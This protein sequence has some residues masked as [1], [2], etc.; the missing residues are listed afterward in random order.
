MP[1]G[2]LSLAR[3]GSNLDDLLSWLADGLSRVIRG[4]L[5]VVG[6]HRDG[7]LDL[8]RLALLDNLGLASLEFGILANLYLKRGAL[9]PLHGLGGGVT[10]GSNL[11]DLL[12]RLSNALGFGRCTRDLRVL[13]GL[14]GGHLILARLALLDSLLSAGRQG[15]IELNLGLERNFDLGLSGVRALSLGTHTDDR[16]GRLLGALRGDGRVTRRLAVDDLLRRSHDLGAVLA[17]LVDDLLASLQRIIKDDFRLER[18]WLLSLGD[19][20][21]VLSLRAV[22]DDFLDRFLGGFALSKVGLITNRTEDGGEGLFAVLALLNN[23]GLT[24]SEVRVYA[25]RGAVGHRN[26]PLGLLSILSGLDANLDDLIDGLFGDLLLDRGF[27]IRLRVGDLLGHRDGLLARL[28]LGDGLRLARRHRRVKLDLHT[29]RHLSLNR[30]RGL[31]RCHCANSDDL[32]DRFFRA[33][34]RHFRVT[35]R[36]AVHDLL[37][38][39]HD[40][41][42]GLTLLVDLLFTLLE[43]V[44]EDDLGLERH[45]LLR[46]G[47]HGGVLSSRAVFDDLVDRVLGLLLFR[48]HRCLVAR[49]REIS[50]VGLLA[51]DA[52]LDDLDLTRLQIRVRA[53]LNLERNLGSPGDLLGCRRRLGAD[54]DD[55]IDGLLGDLLLHGGFAIGLRVGDLLRHGDGLLTGLTLG[56]RLRCASRHVRVKLDLHTERNLGL[57]RIG[58]LTGRLGAHADDLLGW[59]LGALGCHG[60]FTRRLTVNE[61]LS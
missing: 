30:L 58:G 15:V 19:N 35:R 33:L 48:G 53:G 11:D 38:R 45:R 22:L 46:L 18:D 41:G 27:A 36:L 32:L 39:S 3:S 60:G 57:N 23:A 29:E 21:G 43:G 54:L 5:T 24:G 50:G 20:R 9:G 2:Q 16:V 42:A 17:L 10:L 49:G 61:L 7:V 56:H 13:N 31:T 55:L 14:G 12:D 40:L 26:G 8:A 6:S 44:V 59:F 25:H 37:R 47:H 52:L 51:R 34:S 4:D 28:A 1:I